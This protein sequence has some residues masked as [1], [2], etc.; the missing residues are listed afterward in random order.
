MTGIDWHLGAAVLGAVVGVVSGLAAPAVIRRLPEPPPDPAEDPD[1]FPAK[2]PYVE[3]AGRRG[4]A[5]GCAVAGAA[6]GTALGAVLGWTPALAWLL[7]M[8]LPG[9]VLAVVDYVTWYLPS[10][11]IWPT[12]AVVLAI[13]GVAALT[14][15]DPR[16]LGLA[17]LGFV[18]VGGYYGLLWL[19][20]PRV[21]AFGDV[22]LGALLG[23]ALGP[24]GLPTP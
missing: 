5:A 17:A 11:L 18:L 24:F 8:L 14:R 19:V 6:V 7:A 21:M 20:S 9:L 12:A 15:S 16:V 4:L 22:R 1:D 3:L 10:R 23:L 13:E 2:V